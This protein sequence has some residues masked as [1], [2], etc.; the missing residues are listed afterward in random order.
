V[1]TQEL[2]D[3]NQANAKDRAGFAG[4]AAISGVSTRVVFVG[5]NGLL[6]SF[7]TR[8]M[9]ACCSILPRRGE[10]NK[11][12]LILTIFLLDNRLRNG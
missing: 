3:I 1:S 5:W 2:W 8:E 12:S 4:I 9:I 7:G 11:E 6:A 10:L